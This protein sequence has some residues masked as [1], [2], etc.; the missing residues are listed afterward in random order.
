MLELWYQVTPDRVRRLHERLVKA[1]REAREV[2]C[3]A[4]LCPPRPSGFAARVAGTACGFRR[5]NIWRF[6]CAGAKLVT[7]MWTIHASRR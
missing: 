5:P 2:K 3:A 6:Q 4:A 1:L 7:S